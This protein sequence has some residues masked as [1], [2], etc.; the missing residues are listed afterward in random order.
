MHSLILC[1]LTLSSYNNN[2]MPTPKSK[3]DFFLAPFKNLLYLISYT[4]MYSYS[5]FF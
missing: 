3:Y 5:R 2:K 1:S 4:H